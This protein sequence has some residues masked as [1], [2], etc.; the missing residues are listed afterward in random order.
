V[1]N[2]LS[3]VRRRLLVFAVILPWMPIASAQME[4]A[5]RASCSTVGVNPLNVTVTATSMTLGPGHTKNPAHTYYFFRPA[6]AV[7]PPPLQMRPFPATCCGI[8]ASFHINVAL[9]FVGPIIGATPATRWVVPRA[10]YAVLLGTGIEVWF[11]AIA[12]DPSGFAPCMCVTDAVKLR[13]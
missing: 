13:F 8:G 6:L 11:Q 10:A 3:D 7:E 12:I 9:T 1:I 5:R 2:F 4:V